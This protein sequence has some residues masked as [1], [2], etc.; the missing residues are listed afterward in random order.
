MACGQ[1]CAPPLDGSTA[2]LADL[3]VLLSS[4]ENI[5]LSLFLSKLILLLIKFI[6]L[7]GGG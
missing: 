1:V 3:F 6:L 4:A 5:S 7:I 2:T